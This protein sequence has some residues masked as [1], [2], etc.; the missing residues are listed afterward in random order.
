[1]T[2]TI[3]NTAFANVSE[4]NVCREPRRT[5]V[6][7][8]TRGDMLIDMVARKYKLEVTFGLL[9]ENELKALRK[10]S[11]KIFVSVRFLAPEGEVT[12]DFHISDEPAPEV[13][14]VNGVLMYGGVKLILQEK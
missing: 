11:E 4:L 14:I 1:M 13:T 7:Y 6:R 8:N 3:D 10:L 9:S 5:E 12:A 2:I